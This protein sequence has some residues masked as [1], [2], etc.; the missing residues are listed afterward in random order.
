[1]AE[2]REFWEALIG[3]V[4]AE[5]AQGTIGELVASR[6][7]RTPFERKIVD[8]DRDDLS[9]LLRRLASFVYTGW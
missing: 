3:G 8:Y 4:S 6:M 5:M 1:M 9:I 7:D 2:R